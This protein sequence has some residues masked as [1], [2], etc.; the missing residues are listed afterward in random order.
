MIFNQG[1]DYWHSHY[2]NGSFNKIKKEEHV[3]SFGEFFKTRLNE[4]REKED[5]CISISN[6]INEQFGHFKTFKKNGISSSCFVNDPIEYV[7]EF[8]YIRFPDFKNDNLNEFVIRID[9]NPC[10]GK[11]ESMTKIYCS[12]RYTGELPENE[13]LDF[14]KRAENISEPITKIVA[15]KYKQELD[16]FTR[17]YNIDVNGED[18]EDDPAPPYILTSRVVGSNDEGVKKFISLLD[19]PEE[20]NNYCEETLEGKTIIDVLQR[21]NKLNHKDWDISDYKWLKQKVFYKQET[22]NTEKFHEGHGYI[23]FKGDDN[24]GNFIGIADSSPTDL[25]LPIHLNIIRAN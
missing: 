14:L 25:L 13:T 4:A 23:G 1:A 16:E 15:D 24:Y 22:S 17:A 21:I 12:P 11:K 3:D 20:W 5:F 18:R 6:I 2:Y 9:I 7:K 8:K 19:T 10:I